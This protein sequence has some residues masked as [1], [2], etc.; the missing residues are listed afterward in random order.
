MTPILFDPRTAPPNIWPKKTSWEQQYIDEIAKRDVAHMVSNVKTTWRALR[1]KDRIFPVT[2]ND[3]E[4]GGSYVCLPHSAYI[5]YARVEL[6]IVDLGIFA[7]IMRGIIKLADSALL[8]AGINKIV[9]LDNWLLST[10]LHGDWDGQDIPS[11]RKYLTKLYPQHIIALR[12]LDEWSCPKLLQAVQSDN[13]ILLPSRQIWVTEDMDTQWAKTHNTKNDRRLLNK[14]PLHIEP[15]HTMSDKDAQRIA[16]LYHM[17][18]IGKYSALNPV[19][20][21]EYIKMTCQTGMLSFKGARDEFGDLVAIA[22]SLV[23]GGI[24]TPPIVGYDTSRPQKEG[25]Y[26]IACYL[27]SEDARAMGVRVN[28][29][30]GAASFKRHRGATAQ[31]EYSAFYIR[32]LPNK[33]QRTIKQLA[34]L[35][36]SFAVPIMKKKQL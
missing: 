2:I 33:Q 22:G 8:K 7:P 6:G 3:N 24:L 19:F 18:Y 29:S 15:V 11:I 27:F 20:T 17:L 30:A 35:L 9:Q 36:N 10:N 25:L 31:I 16:E 28:G 32:H 26:R 14:T 4:V 1:S 13:W 5:L 34:Y 21:P 12:S 23:R